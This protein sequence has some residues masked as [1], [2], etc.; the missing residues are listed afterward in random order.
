MTD[1]KPRMSEKEA[2]AIVG[3]FGEIVRSVYRGW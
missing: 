2:L 3:E 1:S